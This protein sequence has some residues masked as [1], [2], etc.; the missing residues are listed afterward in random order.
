M[1]LRTQL[2]HPHPDNAIVTKLL[3]QEENENQGIQ[4][5]SKQNMT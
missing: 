1:Y 3:N 2:H 5:K 4:K